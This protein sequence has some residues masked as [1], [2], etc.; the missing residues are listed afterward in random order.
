MT[1]YII[2][3]GEH[4]PCKIGWADDVEARRKQLQVSHHDLLHVMRTIEG[5]RATERWLHQRFAELHM[6]GEWFLFRAEMLVVEPPASEPAPKR[7]K[8]ERLPL[9]SWAADMCSKQ[10]PCARCRAE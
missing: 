5:S 1:V 6:Q 4:G 9:V 10:N 8:K 7:A 3:A 2:R